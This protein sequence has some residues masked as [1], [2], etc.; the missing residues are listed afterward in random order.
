M[1]V[2]AF[3][4]ALERVVSRHI[5][6]ITVLPLHGKFVEVP[7]IDD[8]IKFIENY[9]EESGS[10]PIERYEIRVRY[11]NDDSIEGSFRNK[12]DA[13]SFLRTYIPVPVASISKNI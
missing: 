5:R 6:R 13:I 8:A 4:A 1:D 10:Q 2:R 7:T 9:K 11:N 3:V 12:T